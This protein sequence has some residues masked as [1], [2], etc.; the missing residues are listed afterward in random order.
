MA[1]RYPEL[2]THIDHQTQIGHFV[3]HAQALDHGGFRA[4]SWDPLRDLRTAV[5]DLVVM[6]TIHDLLL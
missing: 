2:V 6:L 4:T 5:E 3:A 1:V